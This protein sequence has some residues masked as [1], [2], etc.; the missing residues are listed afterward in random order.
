[1]CAIFIYLC[2][3]C[4]CRCSQFLLLLFFALYCLLV[5]SFATVFSISFCELFAS[6]YANTRTQAILL[7][8]ATLPHFS[9]HKTECNVAAFP[10]C[11]VSCS[12]SAL[13]APLLL[14]LRSLSLSLYL[15]FQHVSSPLIPHNKINISFLGIE[16]CTK[17]LHRHTHF[18][19]NMF[20]IA[21]CAPHLYFVFVRFGFF[22]TVW[23]YCHSY[24]AVVKCCF[25][26][27]SCIKFYS[28]TNN[29]SNEIIYNS[30][31]HLC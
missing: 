19:R 4:Y 12:P 17:I 29:I 24:V 18:I 31:W 20:S 14:C 23:L 26:I 27:Q 8:L 22:F 2:C 5:R 7:W 30:R 21:F 9:Y 1:M 28:H 3:C 25:S 10:M 13:A 6:I 11:H 16:L 15:T